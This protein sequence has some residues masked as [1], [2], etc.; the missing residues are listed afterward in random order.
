MCN[1]HVKNL[2]FS[3]CETKDVHVEGLNYIITVG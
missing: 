1:T 2:I 3:S